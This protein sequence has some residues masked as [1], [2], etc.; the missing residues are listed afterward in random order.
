MSI[1]GWMMFPTV[2]KFHIHNLE[3]L[4]QQNLKGKKDRICI[5]YALARSAASTWLVVL[6]GRMDQKENRQIMY[7]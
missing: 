1:I 6:A 2:T 7:F 5:I 4:P 3:C